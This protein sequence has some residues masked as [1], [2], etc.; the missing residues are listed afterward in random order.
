MVVTSIDLA[1]AKGPATPR[2]PAK[3]ARQSR[4]KMQLDKLIREAVAVGCEL[5]RIFRVV[6]VVFAAADPVPCV[7]AKIA[8]LTT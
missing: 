1:Q 3:E 2:A 8:L 4:R 5:D 7:P 6:L